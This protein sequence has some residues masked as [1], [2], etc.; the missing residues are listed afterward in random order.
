MY[1]TLA[2]CFRSSLIAE[3]IKTL[4]FEVIIKLTYDNVID[5]A[6]PTSLRLL[7]MM[8]TSRPVD[9]DIVVSRDQLPGSIQ[10]GSS[11]SGTKLV[12]S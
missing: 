5:K 12:H 8:K 7:G 3:K 9:G 1:R 2:K 6:E 10:R 4:S 11:V